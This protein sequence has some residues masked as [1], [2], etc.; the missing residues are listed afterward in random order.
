M[1]ESLR[2]RAA[3]YFRDLQDRIV[4]ALFEWLR[5]P[6]ISADPAR[7]GDVR[8]SAGFCAGLPAR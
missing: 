7:E 8:A 6:S 1:A 4:A 3:G 2:E 5:I